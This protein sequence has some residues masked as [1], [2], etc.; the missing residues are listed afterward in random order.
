MC[1][2][3]QS[4]AKQAGKWIHAGTPQPVREKWSKPFLGV[5]ATGSPNHPWTCYIY[6]KTQP[7]PWHPL[8][9]YIRHVS[10]WIGKGWKI[11]VMAWGGSPQ[12]IPRD[13]D[14]SRTCSTGFSSQASS[15]TLKVWSF[16][17]KDTTSPLVWL[18]T[19]CETRNDLQ[20]LDIPGQC[21]LS[22]FRTSTHRWWNMLEIH[23]ETISFHDFMTQS[24]WP[25]PIRYSSINV[26]RKFVIN[27]LN[28]IEPHNLC[29]QTTYKL[30]YKPS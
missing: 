30:A 11:D 9:K 6:P 18:T 16:P 19:G 28:H 27:S 20:D 21:L 5:L 7:L 13:W 12:E 3:G 4:A 24:F 10:T 17:V 26:P 22:R 23:P 15:S 1:H 2:H 8:E 29:C 14:L 25:I